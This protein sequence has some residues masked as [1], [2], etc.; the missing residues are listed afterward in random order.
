[1][2]RAQAERHTPAYAKAI[3]EGYNKAGE[4]DKLLQPQENLHGFDVPGARQEAP[5]RWHDLQLIS[6]H[7]QPH[8]SATGRH[9]GHQP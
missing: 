5:W 6:P 7:Q 1:M 8:F 3:I 9:W 2:G 4:L